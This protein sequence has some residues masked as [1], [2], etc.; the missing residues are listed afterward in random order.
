MHL[1]GGADYPV[2]K[3]GVCHLRPERILQPYEREN[4]KITQRRRGREGAQRIGNLGDGDF[5]V[6]AEDEAHGVADFAERG[7]GLYGLVDEGHQVLFALDRK[8]VV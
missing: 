6:G 3:L 8:S 5:F 2:R 1:D 4:Q 7:V